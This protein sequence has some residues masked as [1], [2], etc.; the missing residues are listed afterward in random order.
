[1]LTTKKIVRPDPKQVFFYAVAVI[2]ASTLKS[3]VAVEEL[4]PPRLWENSNKNIENLIK[5]AEN[6]EN[7]HPNSR[8]FGLGEKAAPFV[9]AMEI[10]SVQ[11][12][13]NN[14][15]YIY[16]SYIPFSESFKE[17]KRLEMGNFTIV[18]ST[19]LPTEE[20]I[21]HYRALLSEIGLNPMVIYEQYENFKRKTIIVDVT[22]P[23]R[24]IVLF[25]KIMSDWAKKQGVDLKDALEVVTV[26][27]EDFSTQPV[28]FFFTDEELSNVTCTNVYADSDLLNALDYEINYA[29][30]FVDLVP[31]YPAEDWIELVPLIT[32][33]IKQQNKKIIESMNEYVKEY[34]LKASSKTT[35]NTWERDY[36]DFE[37][38]IKVADKLS[39]LYSNAQWYALGKKSAWVLKTT[40][41][42]NIRRSKNNEKYHNYHYVQFSEPFEE[43]QHYEIG[44]FTIGVTEKVLTEDQMNH[45]ESLFR[46]IGLDPMEIQFQYKL[47]K[48]KT[49]ILDFTDSD[50]LIVPVAKTLLDWTKKIGVQLEEALKVV[51]ITE[52]DDLN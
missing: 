47:F 39:N 49:V 13:K 25:T 38:L 35:L 28:S 12:P 22:D 52:E 17:E 29:Q 24:F 26:S 19:W 4:S 41:L 51:T 32:R 45:Y 7:L 3:I 1:M 20:Q 9:T 30:D 18:F 42:L 16:H 44:D 34:L 31:S 6:I 11:K 23:D 14:E 33:E 2:L 36:K 43:Y 10:L 37:N 48:R 46:E 21:I 27:P 40:E 5:T 8:W 50:R 15:S